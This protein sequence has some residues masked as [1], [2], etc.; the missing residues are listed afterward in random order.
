M[1]SNT[2][3][4]VLETDEEI[5]DVLVKTFRLD[6]MAEDEQ[7]EILTKMSTIMFEGV[8]DRSI[9]FLN[10]DEKKE[11]T[12]LFKKDASFEEVMDWL[13][14]HVLEFESIYTEEA[15]KMQRLLTRA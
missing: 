5:R 9:E 7:T 14:L 6:N 13:D 8:L 2:S 3:P 1:S 12:K 10:E 11:L 4:L 15:Q